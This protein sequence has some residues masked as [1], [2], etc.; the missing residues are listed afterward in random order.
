MKGPV[1]NE[2]ERKARKIN[3][4]EEEDSSD[5]ENDV[6]ENIFQ[7]KVMDG[8]DI[9]NA[10][11]KRQMDRIE[12]K[13]DKV[14]ANMDKPGGMQPR[15]NF[16]VDALKTEKAGQAVLSELGSELKNALDDQESLDKHEFKEIMASHGFRPGSAS[17]TLNWMA[18]VASHWDRAE[19]IKGEF[20]GS[21]KPSR[22][23]MNYDGM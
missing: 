16:S 7:D 5:P 1:R 13:L 4:S 18:K 19:F 11:L 17:T 6:D 10:H 3:N 2:R 9:N 21:S 15:N 12:D 22:I 14:L 23:K 8:A 20:G